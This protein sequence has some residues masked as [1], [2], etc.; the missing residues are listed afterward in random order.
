ML[1][2]M[3]C[4]GKILSSIGPGTTSFEQNSPI[5]ISHIFL[6]GGFKRF[7]FSPVLVEMIQFD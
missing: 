6:G 3:F 1:Y 5:F 2:D 4:S 7:L